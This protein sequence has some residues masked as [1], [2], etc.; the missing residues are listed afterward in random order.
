[1]SCEHPVTA[2]YLYPS[3]TVVLDLY[4]QS[5]GGIGIRFAVPCPDCDTTLEMEAPVDS[6]GKTELEIPIEDETD[7]YDD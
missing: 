1:M 7:Q 5:D 4:D 2:E 6:I 3:D